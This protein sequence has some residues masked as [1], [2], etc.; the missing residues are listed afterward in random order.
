MTPQEHT[1]L[2][3]AFEVDRLLKLLTL[4]AKKQHDG[5][6]TI[7]SCTTGYKVAFGTPDLDGG[8]G[9]AQLG[10][11]PACATL[12]EALIAALVAAQ[13]FAD[14]GRGV[15]PRMFQA[16]PQGGMALATQQA[17]F[18]GARPD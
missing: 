8:T 11:I 5:H 17:A 3:R 18:V 6:Y 2:L 9:R 7:F 10:H 16:F 1:T 15:A 4:E 14:Y 13:T 12:K